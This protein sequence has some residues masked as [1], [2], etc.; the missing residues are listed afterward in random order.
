MISFLILI[1]AMKVLSSV[2]RRSTTTMVITIRTTLRTKK[3]KIE[4]HPLRLTKV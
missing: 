3:I 4:M 2:F 1:I